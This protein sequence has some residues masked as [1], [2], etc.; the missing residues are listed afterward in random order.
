MI[1][2]PFIKS[3]SRVLH[4]YVGTA[5]FGGYRRCLTTTV[6]I[7]YRVLDLERGQIFETVNWV[8]LTYE[9]GQ[10]F[11]TV[12]RTSLTYVFHALHK[13]FRPLCF[14]LSDRSLTNGILVCR[15]RYVTS[16][17][18]LTVFSVDGY[19]LSQNTQSKVS[20]MQSHLSNGSENFF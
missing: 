11:E 18:R 7:L 16:V 5:N 8:S 3:H 9:R 4:N 12:N 14:I 6:H 17:T 20:K 10:L 1:H 13:I 2:L 19:C 15:V